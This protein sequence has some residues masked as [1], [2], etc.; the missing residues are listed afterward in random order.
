MSRGGGGEKLSVL[1]IIDHTGGEGG[2]TGRQDEETR[3]D[4][5]RRRGDGGSGLTVDVL[6][7]IEMSECRPP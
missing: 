5:E 2:G 3:D 7:A 4:T 6:D 1:S